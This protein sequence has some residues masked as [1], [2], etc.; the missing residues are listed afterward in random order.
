MDPLEVLADLRSKAT[1]KNLVIGKFEHSEG[2]SWSR[3]NSSLPAHSMPL[4]ETALS[5]YEADLRDPEANTGALIEQA[6]LNGKTFTADEVERLVQKEVER[7]RAEQPPSPTPEL[8]QEKFTPNDPVHGLIHLPLI[9]KAVVDTRV[10]QRMR[11]IRQLGI[12]SHVYPGATHN[13][14]FHSIGTAFLAY[15]LM[16]GLRHRQPELRITDRDVLCVTLAGLC[17]DLGHPCFSHMF[18]VFIHELGRDMRVQAEID[19]KAGGTVVDPET[20]TR[21]QRYESWSHE[22]ASVRLLDVVFDE[23]REPLL[24]AGLRIDGAGDDFT[25]IRELIDPPKRQLE[26]LLSRGELHRAW[27]D[28]I[29][30]RPVEKAWLY[31]VVSNWRSGIDVDKFDYFRRDALYLGIRKEFDHLRYLK[32]V[33]ILPDNTG[34]LTIS[35]P[36]KEKDAI[37]ENMFEL[38]KSL[39]R[40][41]YQHKTAKKLEMHMIDVLKM[42]DPHVQITGAEGRKYTMSQAAV[43]FDPVAYQKL[44]DAFVETKLFEDEE[45]ALHEAV[46]EYNRRMISRQMMTLIADW[47]V[48]STRA[49]VAPLVSEDV[50]DG[51]SEA[52]SVHAATV[53][54]E[55][56]VLAVSREELRCEVCSFHY[57]MRTE[58][59]IRRVLFH[60]SKDSSLKS[61]LSDTDAKPMK[62][63]VYVFWNPS[64]MEST[65]PAYELTHTRLTLAF[66]KWATM[67]GGDAG[68]HAELLSPSRIGRGAEL[69]ADSQDGPVATEAETVRVLLAS[70]RSGNSSGYWGI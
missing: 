35:P 14:F 45:P 55:E 4:S 44:T 56:P 53:R 62:Q 41:A 51:V 30:G 48:D 8:L 66:E 1:H 61:H 13:R 12:C 21:I 33:R 18:E 17:H 2:R 19:A 23:V 26:D 25:C 5:Q 64:H 6:R 27:S 49:E 3:S 70:S 31:E 68:S 59:P 47:D 37:R 20:L 16:K 54:P 11:H 65:D 9:V 29:K 32:A 39:H 34:V 7:A 10:F 69:A 50:I 24:A 15:E 36:D 22:D 63:K 46:L 43:D 28:H 57:G 58:D 52:Y 60:S 42:M 40:S 67:K 38:R